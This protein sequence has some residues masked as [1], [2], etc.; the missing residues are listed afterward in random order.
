MCGH[1]TAVTSYQTY[2]VDRI[3]VMCDVKLKS[4]AVVGVLQGELMAI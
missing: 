4:S 3:E 2:I 1:G